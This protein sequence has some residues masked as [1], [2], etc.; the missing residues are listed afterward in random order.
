MSKEVMPRALAIAL[1]AAIVYG[2]V[3]AGCSRSPEVEPGPAPEGSEATSDERS[4]V[5]PFYLSA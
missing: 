2:G 5:Y 1:S 4:L 3:V